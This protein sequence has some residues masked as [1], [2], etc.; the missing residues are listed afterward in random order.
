MPSPISEISYR[1]SYARKSCSFLTFQLHARHI[2][3]LRKAVFSFLSRDTATKMSFY[4]NSEGAQIGITAAFCFLV[5]VDLIGNT[6][7]CLVVYRN[8]IMR[9]PMNYL[10]V[11]LAASDITVAIFIA[12]RFI[13]PLLLE[14]PKGRAGDVVC[15]LF[16][17][18]AFIWVGAL[19]SAFSLVFIALERYLAIKFPYDVRKRVTTAKLKCVVVFSWAFAALWNLPLFLYARYDPVSESCRF[20]W[21][22]ATITQV[23]SPLS[24]VMYGVLPIS[25]M[26]YLYSKLV[27]KLWF[28]PL[29]TSTM[30]QQSKLR[31]TRKSA[32][33]VVTVSVVYSICWIPN[34]VVYVFS[35]FS[36]QQLYSAVHTTSIV[37]VTF[38]S[39]INPVLYSLQSDRFRRHMLA[40]LPFGCSTRQ[41][42]VSP[43][44][45]SK[46][47]ATSKASRPTQ[48]TP[49]VSRGPFA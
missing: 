45:M 33:L 38:N 24:A 34:L 1:V 16:T 27:Y 13:F 49:L 14:H 35:S 8:R 28:R 4:K 32:R 25:I 21:P 31:Y 30:V 5:I 46:G 9:T 26:S 40:L 22:T 20:K 17:G 39:A 6:L 12:A 19:V 7:V 37:L 11:H 2:F 42:R 23:H 43:A 41:C 29:V 36:T 44:V 18:G 15:Q 48:I 10:L 47:N 3:H